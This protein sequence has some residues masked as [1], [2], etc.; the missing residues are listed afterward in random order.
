MDVEPAHYKILSA[1]VGFALSIGWIYAAASEVVN[2]I[3]MFGDYFSI[4]YQ[5][6]GLTAIAWANSIGDMMA[7]CS[8][9]RQGFSRMAFSAAFGAPLFSKYPIIALSLLIAEEIQISWSASVPH[10]SSQRRRESGC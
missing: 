8:V 9:A 2:L 4:N 3:M 10:S 5:I 6:M 1:Y 7:D